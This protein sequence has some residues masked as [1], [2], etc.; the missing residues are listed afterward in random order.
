[1]LIGAGNDRAFQAYLDGAE[2]RLHLHKFPILMGAARLQLSRGGLA[3]QHYI[4]QRGEPTLLRHYKQVYREVYNAIWYR[5]QKAARTGVSRFMQEKLAFLEANAALRIS[6]ISQSATDAIR[7]A[8]ME[9]VRAGRS[10]EQIASDI[11]AAMPDMSRARA[12]TIARTETH[13]AAMAATAEVIRF[14]GIEV[15][16]KTWVTAHDNRVRSSHAALNGVTV[17]YDEP[18]QAEGG[19]LLFPGDDSLGADAGEIINCRCA[20]L[21]NT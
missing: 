6:G 10:P 19:R 8:V 1:M 14:S 4:H 2:Q 15:K 17:P 18:F 9:G 21:Y 5:D 12:A 20:V 3:A 13:T 11:Y 7:D 16:S